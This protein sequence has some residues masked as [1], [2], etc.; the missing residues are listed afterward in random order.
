MMEEDVV[1]SMETSL[2]ELR[3]GNAT[4]AKT[5]ATSILRYREEGR[6]IVLSCIGAV[7]LSNGVKA[8]AMANGELAQQGMFL[9]VVPGFCTKPLRDRDTG[10]TIEMTSIRLVIGCMTLRSS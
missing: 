4:Q 1:K 9:S 7:A 10:Q 8:V 2:L 5:L 6:S 3:V